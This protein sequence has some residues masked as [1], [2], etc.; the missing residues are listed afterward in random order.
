L[1]ISIEEHLTPG[2][3]QVTTMA[4]VDTEL[5]VGT[6][7]GCLVVAEAS[8]MRPITVFRPFEE[9]VKAI[10]CLPPDGRRPPATQGGAESPV[11]SQRPSALVATVGKGYR[12]LLGRYLPTGGDCLHQNMHA[13]LWRTDPWA[14]P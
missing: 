13:I 8:T 12:N 11:P 2:R 6:T 10:L 4:L 5:Y 9:E 7:W 3:C 1:S 14:E